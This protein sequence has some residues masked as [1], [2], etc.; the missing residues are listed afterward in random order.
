VFV[1]S[2]LTK[3]TPP[4]EA[5]DFTDAEAAILS[6]MKTFSLSDIASGDLTVVFLLDE[7]GDRQID[8]CPEGAVNCD[9]FAILDDPD[10]NLRNV[11]GGRTVNIQDVDI[12]FASGPDG[13]TAT[14]F[15]I[16]V[17]APATQ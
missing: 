3:F 1:Y 14:A 15:D 4:F 13:G 12:T 10:R 7:T 16:R 6:D 2:D 8:G 5:G 9:Q 11:L 17:G